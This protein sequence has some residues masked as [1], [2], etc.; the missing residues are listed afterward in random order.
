EQAPDGKI[1][2]DRI[3]GRIGDHLSRVDGRVDLGR[4][5]HSDCSPKS[6]Y[7][8]GVCAYRTPGRRCKVRTAPEPASARAPICAFTPELKPKLVR[9]LC[10][11]RGTLRDLSRIPRG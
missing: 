6:R 1:H 2:R 3:D 10:R 7:W 5:V 8:R 11:N 9:E 4:G